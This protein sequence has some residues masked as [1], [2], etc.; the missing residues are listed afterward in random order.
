MERA[1]KYLRIYS[2]GLIISIILIFVLV[3]IFVTLFGLG[4]SDAISGNETEQYLFPQIGNI[5][6]IFIVILLLLPVLI[7][8]FKS[9]AESSPTHPPPGKKGN[10]V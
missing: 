5:I 3:L 2:I 10:R 7:Y 4:Q 6:F 9:K 1:M 8:L